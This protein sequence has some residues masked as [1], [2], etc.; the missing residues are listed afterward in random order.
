MVAGSNPAGPTGVAVNTTI[1]KI[2]LLSMGAAT[3][4]IFCQGGQ[5]LEAGFV[6]LDDAT[7]AEELINERLK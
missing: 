3:V 7:K 4:K 1:A 5:K 6:N 2:L